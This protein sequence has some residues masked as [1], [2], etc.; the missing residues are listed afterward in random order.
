V[1]LAAVAGTELRAGLA[2]ER[3]ARRVYAVL[4]PETRGDDGGGIDR[5]EE[6]AAVLAVRRSREIEARRVMAHELK[7]PLTSMRGLTQLLSEYELS[8]EERR[9]VAGLAASEAQRLQGMVEGLLELERLSLRDPSGDAG[10]VDLSVL[11]AE[12]AQIAAAGGHRNIALDL[13]P[14]VKV[15]G[16]A[17]LLGRALDNLLTNALKYSPE[18]T[19]VTVALEA[20]AGNAVL[21][22]IDHG[23]GIPAA[24]RERIFD[25]F[26]RGSTSFGTDGLGLGLALVSEVIAWHKGSITVSE[27]PGGGATFQTSLP[28]VVG[29]AREA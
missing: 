13:A 29:S 27:T 23:P 2:T 10:E 17:L 7:T 21:E 8:V 1:G 9:R 20:V 19:S 12:R 25:R 28:L 6:L 24:E 4:A 26:A 11:V 3:T 5:L 15:R 16:N 22:V 18:T 14:G